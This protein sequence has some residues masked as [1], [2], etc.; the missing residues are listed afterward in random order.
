MKLIKQMVFITALMGGQ[1]LRA[2]QPADQLNNKVD[3]FMAFLF[4]AA[5]GAD[6]LND[7]FNSKN[8]IDIYL[9]SSTF[10]RA[11]TMMDRTSEEFKRVCEALT[12]YRA[13]SL[14]LSDSTLGSII[15]E[16][17][18]SLADTVNE[19]MNNIETTVDVLK[20]MLDLK[21][22]MG[23]REFTIG[24]SPHVMAVVEFR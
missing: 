2:A 10:T 18:P 9:T 22:K 13:V 5:E 4:D 8:D 20:N 6:Y 3:H 11:V 14:A 16:M 1:A 15:M 17:H 24:G 12:K 21:S 19:L 7:V 23:V